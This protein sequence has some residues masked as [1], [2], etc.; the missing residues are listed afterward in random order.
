MPDLDQ[1]TRPDGH[2]VVTAAGELDRT[3]LA[4]LKRALREAFDETSAGVVLDMAD[5]TYIDSSILAA[6]IAESI[7]ADERGSRLVIATGTGGILRSLE[8]KGLTQVMHITTSVDEA[9]ARLSA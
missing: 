9:V 5:T 3:D 8:L 2:R 4:Y 7:D 6:L 1:R